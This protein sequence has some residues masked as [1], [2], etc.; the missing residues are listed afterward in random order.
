MTLD[1]IKAK[2]VLDKNGVTGNERRPVTYWAKN[3]LGTLLLNKPTES[4]T[5]AKMAAI[6]GS[7]KENNNGY[8][9]KTY[10]SEAWSG[11]VI[12]AYLDGKPTRP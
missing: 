2:Y 4:L 9:T 6:K 5:K 7:K 1:E 10:V 3:V 8:P 11:R 12:A